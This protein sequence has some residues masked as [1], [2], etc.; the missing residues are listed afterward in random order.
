MSNPSPTS[1]PIPNDFPRVRAPAA[2]AGAQPK[3]AVVLQD[4]RYV[5]DFSEEELAGRYDMCADLLRQLTAY[6]QRKR[7]ERPEWSNSELL[8]KV[9]RSLHTKG[10]DLTDGEIDWLISRVGG[11]L[12]G[13]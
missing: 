8:A 13:V 9:R 4:G 2:L 3:L 7:V 1:S 10:W 6:C 12:A 5:T 11:E